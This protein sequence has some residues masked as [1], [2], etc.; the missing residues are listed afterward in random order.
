MNDGGAVMDG[1]M[2]HQPA[3]WTTFLDLT[4]RA[5]MCDER[6]CA[7]ILSIDRFAVF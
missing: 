3:R 4:K 2:H 7:F 1:R 5:F 6:R